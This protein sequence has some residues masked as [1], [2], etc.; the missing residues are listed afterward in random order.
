MEASSHQMP[1]TA[2]TL[3]AA[4]QVASRCYAFLWM[5]WTPNLA[6]SRAPPPRFVTRV[7]E[8]VPC[9]RERRYSDV[10]DARNPL[11]GLAYEIQDVFL[12]IVESPVKPKPGAIL[13]AV[14]E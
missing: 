11:M 9:D 3:A 7:V 6:T 10:G 4:S 8:T 5:P 1:P 2:S 12:S 13:R 14:S